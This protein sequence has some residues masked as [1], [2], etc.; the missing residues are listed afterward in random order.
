MK[1]IQ[2]SRVSLLWQMLA[3]LVVVIPHFA[4]LPLWVP[5]LVGITLV[6][7]FMV[8]NGRWSFPNRWAKMIMVLVAGIAVLVSYRAGGGI[9]VTV[10]LLIV[11]FGLKILEIYNQ[12]D[13][14]VVVYVA[15]LVAA[16]AFLFSQT[17]VMA[18]YVL[19]S[20]TVTTTALMT[21]YIN[22]PMSFG[23]P[24]KRV[25]L[26]LLPAIPL[27]MVLFLGMPRLDPLWEVGLDKSIA[28]TGLS[29]TLSPGDI[30]QLTRSAE[31]AFRVTFE[32]EPPA[33]SELYWR[34]LVLNDYDGRRWY[35]QR[36]TKSKQAEIEAAS[37]E[38]YKYELILEPTQ[39]KYIPALDYPT[40]WQQNVHLQPG[41]ILNSQAIVST[42]KQYIISSLSG[43]AIDK[44]KELFDFSR[45]LIIPDGNPRAREYAHKLWRETGD[46]EKYI[47]E[48]L[49]LFN[50]DFIYS[51]T[52]PKLGFHS[53]DEFL[54][55][56]RKGFCEH[57]SSSMTF[58][59]RAVGIPARV[60]T[61]YQGGE[62]NPYENYLL[63]RQY[64]AHAWVEAWMPDVG[65]KRLDPTAAVSPDRIEKP[66]DRSLSRESDFLND[67]PFIAMG[68]RGS[69]LFSDV[70]L[71]MEAFNYGWHRWVLNYHHQ[72]IG[73]LQNMLGGFTPLRLALFFL[74]PFILIIGF[75]TLMMLRQNRKV[76]VDRFD[77]LVISLS[78]A[79]E[80]KGLKRGRGETVSNYCQR[81]SDVRPDM[82][83]SLAS[84]AQCYEH[85]R[86]A[87]SASDQN[88]R[89]FSKQVERCIKGLR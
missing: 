54:F 58:M 6:W 83:A 63:V 55:D 32:E 82:A 67:S 85:I 15:Y 24:F 19:F 52:P 80:S 87:D 57:F 22:K 18:L 23:Q 9:S 36:K 84:L 11:G 48:V 89:D 5:S 44:S 62:W 73:L 45:Q 51:L 21:I 41:Y 10:S 26:M 4:H 33:Q 59:L 7:R 75:T 29:D 43:A 46:A 25:S 14:L 16:T 65:W 20:I 12:R 37:G 1:S 8:F 34:A 47:A 88:Y 40:S 70:R 3:V 79:M 50:Q 2:L 78:K 30:S 81:L 49:N 64:D 27:M 71:R 39:K 31:V 28:K 56:T 13:A 74:V 66:A 61:G 76:R 60:V 35:N 68:I 53:I 86:Y 17:I 77:V 42:R 38:N 72:Q 69:S